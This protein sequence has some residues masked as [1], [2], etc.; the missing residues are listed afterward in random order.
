MATTTNYGLTKPTVGGDAATWGGLLNANFDTLDTSLWDVNNHSVKTDLLTLDGSTSGS[1]IVQA[2]ATASGTLT[3][4][5]ATDTLVGRATTDTLTGKTFDTA[6]AGNVLRING[7][8]ISAVTGS[9]AAVLATSPALVTPDLGTP[10]A[11]VL[12]ACTGLPVASGISGFGSGVSTF[13]ATPSSANLAAAVTD[14]TGSGALVFDTSPTLTTPTIAS[15]VLTGTL[16]AGGAVGTSGQV[17]QSTGTGVQWGTVAS[18]GGT[19]TSITAGTGLT[20]GTITGSGTIAIDSTVAT[21][22]GTQTLT[23]KTID[24]AS[25]TFRING[26]SISA[27]TGSNSVV[28]STSPTLVTPNIGAATGTSISVSGTVSDAIGNVREIPQNSKTS[29]YTLV[30]ADSG[31]HISITTGG[32]TVPASVF[33]A[34]QAITIFNNSGSNQTITATGV[35]MYQAGTANT[36]NRTLAQ[37]GVATVLCVAS[38]TF[39]ISGAGVS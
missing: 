33:S 5:A 36:G 38:N 14:E 20:G 26:T 28:L 3:L 24:T 6:G 39:V 32:V 9:G 34:G 30:A 29:A 13:L 7:T 37:R 31:K 18:S 17:L 23:N 19:V 8:A 25:N 10:S 1:T 22:T 16:T 11:G 15:G 27:V 2:G 35:T 12:T 4:P 21:L